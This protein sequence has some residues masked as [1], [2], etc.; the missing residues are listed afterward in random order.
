MGTQLVNDGTAMCIVPDAECILFPMHHP[1]QV[2]QATPPLYSQSR[3]SILSLAKKELGLY[4]F[5]VDQL[6]FYNESANLR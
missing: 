5:S 4:L 1:S 2:V 6:S 3:L